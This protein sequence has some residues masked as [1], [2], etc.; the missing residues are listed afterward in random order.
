[1]F[2]NICLGISIILLLIGLWYVWT[3]I[4][5]QWVCNDIY[6][7]KPLYTKYKVLR[8]V[9]SK[10][11][12]KEIIREAENYGSIHGWTTR[13]HDDYPTTD[14]LMTDAWVNYEPV[15]QQIKSVIFP[16]LVELFELKPNLLRMEET[17]IARYDADVKDAQTALGPHEDGSEF[18]FIVA[19]N[20]DYNG[21]GTHF[22][23]KNK[24]VHLNTGDAVIFCGQTTHSGLPVIQGTR[25]IMPGFI[26]YGWCIQQY[27]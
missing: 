8:G 5:H 3:C 11:E 26:Y 2:Y 27:E 7:Q 25:F 12:C 15:M 13:R 20:D 16:S 6:E 24:I 17:F 14:N 21:G 4:Q 1:M 10:K 19:L 9:F 18:S 23:K 22:I